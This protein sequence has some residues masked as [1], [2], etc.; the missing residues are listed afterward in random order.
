MVAVGMQGLRNF[1]GMLHPLQIPQYKLFIRCILASGFVIIGSLSA[2]AQSSLDEVA[3]PRPGIHLQLDKPVYGRGEIIWFNAYVFAS[4]GKPIGSTLQVELFQ[5]DSAIVRVKYPL[6]LGVTEGQLAIPKELPTGWYRMRAFTEESSLAFFSCHLYILGNQTPTKNGRLSS[7][8]S[9]ALT[10]HPESDQ[11]IDG[12]ETLIAFKA[13][14]RYGNPQKISGRILDQQG[15]LVTTFSSWSRGM[16]DFMLT[17]ESGKIYYAEWQVSDRKFRQALPEVQSAGTSLSLI[18]HPEGFLF[19]IKRKEKNESKKGVW[20]SGQMNG[21]EVFNQPLSK[22]VDL[23]QGVLKTK[24]LS[25]GVLHIRVLS[26]D[27]ITLSS[28]KVFVNNKEYR[29]PISLRVDTLSVLPKGKN[30][31]TILLPD[32][33]QGSCSISITDAEMDGG[34]YR[35]PSLLS[36]VLL[37]AGISDKVFQPDWYFQ[38]TKDSADIGLD[39]LML[40]HK[41]MRSSADDIKPVAGNANKKGFITI[42]GQALLRGT[43]QPLANSRLMAVFSGN[44]MRSQILF[45]DTDPAGRF[46]IDSLLF[47]G[48]ARLFFAEQRIKKKPRFIDIRLAQDSIQNLVGPAG[49]ESYRLTN[50]IPDDTP[51]DLSWMKDYEDII[52]KAEGLTLEEVTIKTRSKSPLE[53]LQEEYTTGAFDTDA[54]VERV[55]DLVNT[56][57]AN[58]YPNIF[59]YLR[60][61]IPGLQ[62]ME[63]DYSR[64]PPDISGDMRNDPTKYR[65]FFRQMPSASSMGNI[66]MV[67][68][69]N[70]IETDADILLTI[71]AAEIALVKI[72]SSFTAAPGGGP[73]GALAIYTKKPDLLRET[74]GSAATYSGYSAISPFPIPRYDIDPSAQNKPDGRITL[75]WR[76]NIFLS[77][78]RKQIP[79]RFYNNDRTKRFR[80]VAEGMTTTGKPIFFERTIEGND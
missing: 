60:F 72:F 14:D 73:G 46:S 28:R 32:S 61:R 38:T 30:R 41:E 6:V 44:K 68:Y 15:Q 63:P 77:N 43:R 9:I 21:Q 36:R 26:E 25:S 20:L 10:F 5:L 50:R 75:D 37:T 16:G 64:P 69:L 40:T 12:I 18:N 13:T 34:L 79:I 74:N 57:E 62:V 7:N 52:R 59:E 47:F 3:A 35:Q 80:I 66:P 19:D 76:P 23:I 8:D 49:W 71:P 70:E 56:D 11:L 48:R 29:L 67:I 33:L 2:S 1:T 24:Q 65:I 45:T 22:N 78:D 39:L 54:F 53:K 58:V 51:S 31:W 4:E 27:G 42:Q 55:I 17:P